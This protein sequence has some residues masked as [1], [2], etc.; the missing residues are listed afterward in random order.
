VVLTTALCLALRHA[1]TSKSLISA[2][3]V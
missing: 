3:T 2:G 1:R